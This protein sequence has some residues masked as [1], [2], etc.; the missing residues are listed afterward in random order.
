MYDGFTRTVEAQCTDNLDLPLLVR[1][2]DNRLLSVNFADELEAALREVKYLKE[3]NC[4]EIPE[5]A[6]QVYQQNDNLRLFKNNL[7]ITVKWYNKIIQ[8]TIEVCVC[9]C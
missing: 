7:D 2:A 8:S 6:D 1:N 4:E 5:V 3:R 9:V